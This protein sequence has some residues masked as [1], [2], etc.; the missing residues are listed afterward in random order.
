MN[1]FSDIEVKLLVAEKLRDAESRRLAATV[2]R[3]ERPSR[4][5]RMFGLRAPVL[6]GA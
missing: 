1:P 2:R 6:Q 3:N 4:V 5:G